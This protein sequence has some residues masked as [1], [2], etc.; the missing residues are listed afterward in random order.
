MTPAETII[1]AVIML[2]GL[3]GSALFSGLETGIYSLSRVRLELAAR[4]PGTRSRGAGVLL[5]ELDR[6][7]SL[8]TTILVGN[9]ACNYL[10]T[11]GL[12]TLLL[13]GGLSPAAAVLVQTLVLTPV[14]VIFG[15]SLPKEVFRLRADTLPARLGAAVLAVRTALV[16]TGVLGL[17]L[18]L[19]RTASRLAGIRPERAVS[20][21]SEQ[22]A[23]MIRE[24][25]SAGSL[26]GVQGDLAERALA[27]DRAAVRDVMVPW[28]DVVGLPAGATRADA[29]R[30]ILRK[31]PTSYPMV[32]RAASDAHGAHG[33]QAAPR[34]VGVI[35]T[36]DL[37]AGSALE[38]GD[39]IAEPARIGPGTPVPRA[40]G[41]LRASGAALAIVEDQGRPVGVVTAKDLVEPLTGRLSDW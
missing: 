14:L 29:M 19:V 28:H 41:Q 39:V 18:A 17:M 35:N 40:L 24:S 30:A 2:A 3:A 9:N 8:L 27:F 16:W 4:A 33:P 31:G 26:S 34:V 21:P 38:P 15:E 22:I 25:A 13:A 6:P 32:E 1:W 10:G 23:A 36:A 37:L 5:R 12:G 7:E 20:G 11:L